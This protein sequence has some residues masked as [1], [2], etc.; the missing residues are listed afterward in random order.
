[1]S[2]GFLSLFSLG[3]FA[4]FG[5]V[6]RFA[7]AVDEVVRKLEVASI[8]SSLVTL[9]FEIHSKVSSGGFSPGLI[10]LLTLNTSALPP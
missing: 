4:I 7:R 5:S 9:C 10:S 3:V 6:E 1:V 2:L 8:Y